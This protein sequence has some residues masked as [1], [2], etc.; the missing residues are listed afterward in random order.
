MVSASVPPAVADQVTTTFASHVDALKDLVE[1]DE[2]VPMTVS[3]MA[4]LIKGFQ[5]AGLDFVALSK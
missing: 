1:A 5:S 4:D 2:L 3:D